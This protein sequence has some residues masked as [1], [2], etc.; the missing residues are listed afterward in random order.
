MKQPNDPSNDDND[1]FLCK[2]EDLFFRN[3]TPLQL[4][5]TNPSDIVFLSSACLQFLTGSPQ[6]SEGV[7]KAMTVAAKDVGA[8][9]AV[10]QCFDEAKKANV[11]APSF[12]VPLFIFM[13]EY[14]TN[15]VNIKAYKDAT[16]EE[17]S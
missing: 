1:K 4:T 13:M 3:L 14:V 9:E 12:M 8:E 16:G 2:Q 11:K 7:L 17:P 6:L 10:K 15:P 5:I